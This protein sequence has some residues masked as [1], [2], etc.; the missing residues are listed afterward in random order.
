YGDNPPPGATFNLGL[1]AQNVWQWWWDRKAIGAT[2]GSYDMPLVFRSGIGMDPYT[3][4]V[5]TQTPCPVKTRLTLLPA[6]RVCLLPGSPCERRCPLIRSR[7]CA[8]RGCACCWVQRY[9]AG[10]GVAYAFRRG[11]FHPLR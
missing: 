6:L 10:A 7:R 2:N 1:A 11:W 4:V 3:G 8:D 5:S 9:G